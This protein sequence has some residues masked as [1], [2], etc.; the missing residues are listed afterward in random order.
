MGS[1]MQAC[2]LAFP[3]MPSL[4]HAHTGVATRHSTTLASQ[5]AHIPKPPLYPKPKFETG[6]RGSE[7]VARPRYLFLARLR[8]IREARKKQRR[9]EI[10]EKRWL[11]SDRWMLLG[12]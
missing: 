1:W 4:F 6:R 11:V 2:R 3:H 5:H 12:S 7:E 8:R 10:K 9:K